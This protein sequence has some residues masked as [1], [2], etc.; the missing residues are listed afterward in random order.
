MMMMI[1]FNVFFPNWI[2]SLFCK[3]CAP[4]CLTW[5]N[6]AVVIYLSKVLKTISPLKSTY[7][8]ALHSV[9]KSSEKDHMNFP[10]KT[11]QNWIYVKSG[12]FFVN[13]DKALIFG[14]KFQMTW[15]F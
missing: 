15:K 12:D 6:N 13:V 8:K 9:L 14:A 4:S 2:S 10:A 5:Q 3:T 1:S 11:I 7:K